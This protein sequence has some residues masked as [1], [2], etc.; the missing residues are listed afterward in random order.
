MR[1]LSDLGDP[2]LGRQE[3]HQ[4]ED[5]FYVEHND[6]CSGTSYWLVGQ[7]LP[8]GFWG[9]IRVLT[10]V[11][12]IGSLA[13]PAAPQAIWKTLTHVGPLELKISKFA[14]FGDPPFGPKIYGIGTF[15]EDDVEKTGII[16]EKFD[17]DLRKH[18][19]QTSGRLA[20][21]FTRL[22][23]FTTQ[24]ALK[25]LLQQIR[26]MHEAG[27]SHNDLNPLNILVRLDTEG[28]ISEFRVA[29]F[30]ITNRL[31]ASERLEAK[32]ESWINTYAKHILGIEEVEEQLPGASLNDGWMELAL[33]HV[34]DRFDFYRQTPP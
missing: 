30:T 34:V 19:I 9:R 28:R 11:V 14:E 27:L 17:M 24:A 1:N 2:A 32:V 33:E 22:P 7:E 12:A 4:V 20:H 8:R 25:Q 23:H 16:M 5:R 29:D 6:F 10:K 21:L 31:R 26:F 13:D 15:E 3:L 18:C